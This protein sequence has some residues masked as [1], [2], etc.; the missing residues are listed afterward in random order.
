M[1]G[2][3]II[4]SW[5]RQQ[6][7]IA[8]S[9]AEAETYGM[10]ACSAELL[11]LQACA[12]DLGVSYK[13]A[14]YADASAAL[15][16]VKRRGIGKVRHIRT[17]SLWLQEAHAEKRLAFEKI[18]GSRNPA[19]L[20][21]KYLSE[22]LLDRHLQFLNCTPEDGRA[23]LAPTLDSLGLSTRAFQGFRLRAA[24]VDKGAAPGV[25]KNS[26]G[27]AGHNAT[28]NVMDRGK[29]KAIKKGIAQETLPGHKM[30]PNNESAP[31]AQSG[32][33]EER[34]GCSA[35]SAAASVGGPTI[36]QRRPLQ[37]GGRGEGAAESA[38][39]SKRRTG[40][41]AIGRWADVE[42]S[43]SELEQHVDS[44]E[45]YDNDTQTK[46]ECR[47]PED[48]SSWASTSLE[49]LMHKSLIEYNEHP[50]IVTL[51]LELNSCTCIY[52]D[53][54]VRTHFAQGDSKQLWCKKGKEHIYTC[55]YPISVVAE[56][57]CKYQ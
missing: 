41:T 12:R 48:I 51:K 40:T 47:N 33:T 39:T 34:S 5:S 38:I 10:V 42:S 29:D 3:H 13:L 24:R 32:R 16:I 11:G 30:D 21:T 2:R 26:E 19:D 17:Q 22:I 43:C 53:M 57:R 55:I 50:T 56:R 4:K 20:L 6:K 9:S 35:Q 27:A 45:D 23:A 44:L 8:L 54:C 14:V 25:D 37:N 28:G 18:D 1:A 52:I 15:G 36:Q 31:E 49:T 7:T 46:E